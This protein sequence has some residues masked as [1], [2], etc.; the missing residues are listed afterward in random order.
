MEKLVLSFKSSPYTQK[1]NELKLNRITS[2]I[3]GAVF[4]DPRLRLLTAE[5]DTNEKNFF[6]LS[7]SF[8][9]ISFY[10]KKVTR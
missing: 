3:M 9:D 5:K 10:P 6:F 1:R 4:K 8:V 7:K 2:K